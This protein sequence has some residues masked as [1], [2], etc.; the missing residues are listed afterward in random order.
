MNG[1]L[2]IT[3]ERYI[4]ELCGGRFE[5]PGECVNCDGVRLRDLADPAVRSWMDSQDAS[6]R[7]QRLKSVLFTSAALSLLVSF[8]LREFMNPLPAPPEVI[9][10]IS[11]LTLSLILGR[12]FRAPRMAPDLSDAEE[13]WLRS[14]RHTHRSPPKHTMSHPG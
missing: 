5:A 14:L 8:G 11:A 3:C 7:N 6:R 4:C 10:L 2:K 1:R 12:L 9:W 13:R